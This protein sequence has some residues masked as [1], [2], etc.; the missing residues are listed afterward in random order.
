MS[1]NHASIAIDEDEKHQH[2]SRQHP[3]LLYKVTR[4]N[5]MDNSF[6]GWYPTEGTSDENCVADKSSVSVECLNGDFYSDLEIAVISCVPKEAECLFELTSDPCE[7]FNL[8]VLQAGLVRI[9][10]EKLKAAN[11]TG[12]PAANRPYEPKSNSDLYGGLWVP[13]PD[14]HEI[15][16]RVPMSFDDHFLLKHT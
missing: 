11:R 6:L 16:D 9:L 4:G 14:E 12:I 2:S 5:E 1:A 13:W 7:Q 15:V 8:A 3:A 10:K